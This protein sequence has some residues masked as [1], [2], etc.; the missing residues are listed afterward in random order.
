MNPNRIAR[1]L[2]KMNE[3]GLDSLFLCDIQS[4]QYLT[5]L[6]VYPG[7]RL[8]AL[9]LRSSGEHVFFANRLFGEIRADY[10]VI[11]MD[12]TDDIISIVAKELESSRLM[13]VDKVLAARWLLPLMEKNGHCRFVLGS[14]CVDDVRACKD[15]EEKE[16]MREASRINDECIVLLA[17]Y[18]HEGITEVE[19][20]AYLDRLYAER[21]CT[22]SF[23]SI[24]SFGANGADPHHVC[25]DTPLRPGDGIVIDIGCKYR[26][27]CADMTRT[28]FYKYA[29]AEY[30]EIYN[31]VLRANEAAEKFVKAGQR[32][33]DIDAT[34]RDIIAD[35]GY[36]EYFTHRLGHFIG[37]EVHEKGDVSAAWKS[38]AKA[39][40]VFSI[41]PGIYLPG[42]FGV[43][44]ED[45]VLVT[46][47]GCEILNHVSK[48]LTVLG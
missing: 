37:R 28:Y 34:A 36:G 3:Q 41:E 31:I 2:E 13:G 16:L 30:A 40:N 21:G 6:L 1:V 8:W 18:L 29:P 45:L 48:E 39:G 42:K 25:D 26:G 5:D 43:R 7:E 35:K 38:T 22:T 15:E 44:I 9:C 19:A 14:D 23:E 46:E 27:Y 17:H 10:P 20:A 11:V 12:D 33:C 47:D 24:V 4:I 32:L